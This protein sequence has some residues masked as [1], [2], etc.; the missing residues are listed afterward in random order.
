MSQK[1]RYRTVFLSDIHLGTR[2]CHAHHVA[3]LLKRVRC[4]KLYLV[5]DIVDMWRLKKKW[6]WNDDHNDVIRRVLKLAK[7]GTEVVFIPGNH[8]EAARQFFHMDFAGVKVK[9]YDV[10][11]AADGRRLFVTHGDQY[12]LVVKHSRLLSMLGSAAYE[13]LIRLNVVYNR[14]R[15]LL[16]LK[17]W[18]LSKFLKLKVK[19]ACTFISRYEDTLVHEAKRREMDGV[20]CGHIHQAEDRVIDGIAYYNCGDWV[21]SCTLLVE[22]EDGRMELLDGL[23]LLAEPSNKSLHDTLP[24]DADDLDPVETIAVERFAFLE[25]A[26]AGTSKH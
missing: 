14:G 1:L 13:W 17:Y 8:D 9:P 19:Q 3:R 2:G 7:K 22:H 6:Y 12:D 16:G 21:E 15:S 11:V 4:D 24:I 23:E 5:G 25:E 18:S 26:L 10:H 20:V